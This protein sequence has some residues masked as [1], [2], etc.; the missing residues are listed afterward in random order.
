MDFLKGL[1]SIKLKVGKTY[2]FAIAA[3]III[4]DV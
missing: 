1:K 3:I 2:D 4:A